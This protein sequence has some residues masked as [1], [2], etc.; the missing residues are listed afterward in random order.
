MWHYQ[1]P[2]KIHFGPDSFDHVA[3]LISGRRYA[4]V[5]YDEP[6][7][8]YLIRRLQNMAGTMATHVKNIRPNPDFS[9]LRASVSFLNDCPIKSEVIVA[10]GGGSVIDA[11]KVLAIGG[12]GFDAVRNYLESNDDRHLLPNEALPII[13]IPT[14]AGTGSEVTPWATVWDTESAKKYSL[15][16]DDLFPTDAVIDPALMASLPLDQTINTGLDALSHALESI[17]NINANPV[18]TNYAIR[19]ARDILECLRPLAGDLDSGD[20]RCRMA[21]AATM[22][23]L[24]F[25]GTRTALAHSLS[26]P[27]TLHYGIPHGVACSFTLPAV[28]RSAIGV[29]ATCDNTLHEI[30]GADLNQASRFLGKFLAALGI[31]E[32]H[33]LHG[34]E[35]A[36]W[37]S[38]IDQAIEGE[39][40]QNFIAPRNRIY[41]AFRLSAC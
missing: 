36:E 41:E 15:T 4:T 40:G 38:W 20:L 34:I 24:A 30:F 33:K 18:S 3:T 27:A 21:Q 17:W 26:Y 8:D 29:D 25:S 14:T 35:D 11:A 39:R 2:V 28:M 22:A 12:N 16:R 32:D 23:G 1:N 37:R 6:Y 7:F 9:T 19:A 5:T 31:S 13:A 10:V